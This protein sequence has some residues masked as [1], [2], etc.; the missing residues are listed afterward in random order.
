MKNEIERSQQ[1]ALNAEK[2]ANTA[3]FQANSEKEKAE[4]KKS[5]L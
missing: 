3:I 5:E 2:R 4:K 1:E